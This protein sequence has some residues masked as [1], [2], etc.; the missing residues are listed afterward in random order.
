M[1]SLF[2]RGVREI[3]IANKY[4][5]IYIE[6]NLSIRLENDKLDN[7]WCYV[8][9]P[10][11]PH[12]DLGRY[13]AAFECAFCTDILYS[14]DVVKDIETKLISLVQF[15]K[16]LIDLDEH[17]DV[18]LEIHGSKTLSVSLSKKNDAFQDLADVIEDINIM[19]NNDK[20]DNFEH[21]SSIVSSVNKAYREVFLK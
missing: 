6:N 21:Y 10:I 9:E 4:R 16:G 1:A 8:S 14:D 13:R 19:L 17:C 2:M 12:N 7:Y 11:E 20:L 3:V 5:F 15:D 18:F